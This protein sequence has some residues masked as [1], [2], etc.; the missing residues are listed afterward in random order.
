MR[1]WV[2]P[3][4]AVVRLKV[5]DAADPARSVETEATTTVANAWETLVFDF[6]RAAAGTAALDTAARYNKASVFF[7]FGK[8][9]AAGGAGTY[10]FDDLVFGP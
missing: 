6:S 5:E 1:V 4:G 9:G 2:P 8:T 7:A 3:A 10:Y